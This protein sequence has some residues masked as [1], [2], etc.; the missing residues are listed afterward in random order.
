MVAERESALVVFDLRTR[1]DV[2]LCVCCVFIVTMPLPRGD[3]TS[4]NVFI[5]LGAMVLSWCKRSACVCVCVCVCVCLRVCVCAQGY[6]SVCT[7]V[8][9]Y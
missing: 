7:C 5:L 9:E 6:V 4:P 3:I 8:S 2:T 1:V